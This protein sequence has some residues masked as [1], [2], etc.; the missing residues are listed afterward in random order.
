MKD[1]QLTGPDDDMNTVPR[2]KFW[3][4]E[5]FL[6]CPVVGQ[7][8]SIEEQR[9]VL[10]RA[11]M[12]SKKLSRYELHE[13]LVSCASDENC[14][15]TRVDALLHRKYGREA[16]A[17]LRL[18]HD[19]FMAR[20]RNAFKAGDYCAAFWAA[21]IHP[22]LPVESLREIFGE[23]HMAMHFNGD[24][25]MKMIRKIGAQED[26]IATLDTRAKDASAQRRS[27]QK[28]NN[29][30]KRAVADLEAKIASSEREKE[31]LAS[32]LST[33]RRSGTDTPVQE[34]SAF[35]KQMSALEQELAKTRQREKALS[36]ENQRLTSELDQQRENALLFRQEARDV[37]SRMTKMGHCNPTCPSF[38]LC[39]KRILIVG[40]IERMESLYRELIENSNGIFE[41]HDG[42]IKNGV[43]K[44]ES[45][46]KRADVV[47]CPVNCNS[48]GAC[49]VVK[50]LAKKHR[51]TVHMLSNSS[52]S[53]VS[54]VLHGGNAAQASLN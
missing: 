21:A 45:R 30:L 42:H 18:D 12:P 40:G 31:I 8:M 1:K 34:G 24:E 23:V 5:D 22:N 32:A 14:L 19:T 4:I 36:S 53:T 28:E 29:R 47:L 16:E 27:L 7:C 41:Y 46:L 50:N 6:I 25:R 26:E 51:K 13:I 9:L 43:K 44:L 37:I 35:Q 54:G 20:Y 2:F 49:S 11:K 17:L 48:H 52:I 3:Q 10:K 15:S 39:N 33:A 38:D